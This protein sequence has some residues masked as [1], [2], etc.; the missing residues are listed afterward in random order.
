MQHGSVVQVVDAIRNTRDVDTN[1]HGLNQLR[2]ALESGANLAFL[3]QYT[4]HAGGFDDL[5]AVWDAQLTVQNYNVTVTLLLALA[6]VLRVVASARNQQ[7]PQQ[8][9]DGSIGLTHELRNATAALVQAILSRRLKAIYFNLSS[10]MRGKANAALTLLAAV[11]TQ[12]PETT[13]ELAR[14]FD[15]SLAALP[16]LARLP[17]QRKGDTHAEGADH[18]AGSQTRLWQQWK[19]GDMLKR[20]TRVGFVAFALGMLRHADPLTL[21]TLLATRPLTGGLLNHMAGDPPEVQLQVLGMLRSRVLSHK[22]GVPAATQAEVLSD[23]VLSQLSQLAVT[24]HTDDTAQGHEEVAQQAAN[25]AYKLLAEVVMD[26]RHGLCS[27]AAA[28]EGGTDVTLAS[29]V[30][31]QLSAGQR[32]LL[33]WLQRLRPAESTAH[34][35]LIAACTAADPALA[36]ALLLSLPFT[37]EPALSGRWLAHAAVAGGLMQRVA[38]VRVGLSQL[39]Q[40]GAPAPA[41]ES[42]LMLGLLRCALPPCL[43]K[44]A[45]SRG[46]QRSSTLVRHTTLCLLARVLDTAAALLRDVAA[47][48]RQLAVDSRLLQS[49]SAA[50]LPCRGGGGSVRPLAGSRAQLRWAELGLAIQTAVRTGLPDPQPLLA[51]F[52][53]LQRTGAGLG[54]AAKAGSGKDKRTALAAAAEG[55]D[56]LLAGQAMQHWVVE[57]EEEEDVVVI[58]SGEVPDKPQ[59]G[60]ASADDHGKGTDDTNLAAVEGPPHEG[61]NGV[62]EQQAGCKSGLAAANSELLS[63]LLR[64]LVGWQRSLPGALAESHVD[65]ERLVPQDLLALRPHH[66]LLFLELLLA[67]LP[68]PASASNEPRLLSGYPGNSGSGALVPL[69]ATL[70]LPVLRLLCGAQHGEVSQLARRWALARLAATGAFHGQEDEALVWVDLLPRSA[71]CPSAPAVCGFLTDALQQLQRKPHEFYELAQQAAIGPSSGSD[72][73]LTRE[74]DEAAAAAAAA[75]AGLHSEHTNG[76]TEVGGPLGFSLLALCALRQALRVLPSP[77]MAGEDKAAICAYVAAVLGLLCQQQHSTHSSSRSSSPAVDKTKDAAAAPAVDSSGSVGAAHR[78][79]RT[80]L[81]VLRLEAQRTAQQQHQQDGGGAGAASEGDLKRRH[82]EATRHAAASA[83]GTSPGSLAAELGLLFPPEGSCIVSLVELLESQLQPGPAGPAALVNG[84]GPAAEP[85]LGAEPSSAHAHARKKRKKSS[86]GEAA[87]EG[88]AAL[89]AQLDTEQLSQLAEPGQQTQQAAASLRHSLL[90]ALHAE[91]AAALPTVAASALPGD[92]SHQ[93]AAKLVTDICLAHSLPLPLPDALVRAGLEPEHAIAAYRALLEAAPLGLLLHT[94]A[95]CCRLL[96]GA[97]P[98][99][100]DSRSTSSGQSAGGRLRLQAG[101]EVLAALQRR[102]DSEAGSCGHE[103]QGLQRLGLVRHCL[104]WLERATSAAQVQWLF[105]ALQL[106]LS[107]LTVSKLAERPQQGCMHQAQTAALSML[108]AHPNVQASLAPSPQQQETAMHAAVALGTVSLLRQQLSGAAG[109]REAA[110]VAAACKPLLRLIAAAFLTLARAAAGGGGG[111]MAG[112]GCAAGDATSGKESKKEKKEGKDNQAGN[113]A[114]ADAVPPRN[115]ALGL[116]GKGLPPAALYWEQLLPWME[117][118]DVQEAARLLLLGY[119]THSEGLAD[120]LGSQQMA[121]DAGWVAGTAVSTIS[122]LV[123]G[124]HG[125]M[126]ES[127]LLR[128]C[129]WLLTRLAVSRSQCALARKAEDCLL[130]LLS[131]PHSQPAIEM[132]EAP[133]PSVSLETLADNSTGPDAPAAAGEGEPPAVK[134]LLKAGLDRPSATAARLLLLLVTRSPAARSGFGEAAAAVLLQQGFQTEAQ[135]SGKV[136]GKVNGSRKEKDGRKGSKERAASLKEGQEQQQEQ[137]QEG[138]EN[139]LL[140][141]ACMLPAATALL[142]A[143]VQVP[144]VRQHQQQQQAVGTGNRMDSAGSAGWQVKAAELAACL[145]GPLQTFL[146]GRQASPA[147]HAQRKGASAAPTPA[148]HDSLAGMLHAYAVPALQLCLQVQPPSQEDLERLL[149]RLL[150]AKGFGLGAATAPS[151]KEQQ[152]LK[153]SHLALRHSLTA[154]AVEV[155][156]AAMVVL[157]AVQARPGQQPSAALLLRYLQPY[158]ATLAALFKVP[159]LPPGQRQLEALLLSHLDGALGDAVAALPAAERATPTFARL[160][161][162]ACGLGTAVLRHR[163]ADAVAMR[164]LRRFMAAL[165]PDDSAELAAG[166]ESDGLQGPASREEAKEPAKLQGGRVG[167][168]KGV[169]TVDGGKTSTD[170]GQDDEATPSSSDDSEDE[171]TSDSEGG[172]LGG[173]AQPAAKLPGSSSGSLHN[174]LVAASALELLQRVMTHSRFV[175]AMRAGGGC[176]PALPAGAEDLPRPLQ[177]LLPLAELPE[178]CLA[179]AQEPAAGLKKELCELLE[180][181][182]DLQEVYGGDEAGQGAP[183]VQQ[184]EAALLPLLMAGYGASLSPTDRAVWSLAQAIN[185]RLWRRAR[186]A[187]RHSMDVD[188]GS[189]QSDSDRDSEG[190]GAQESDDSGREAVAALLEGSLADTGLAWGPAATALQASGLR[191]AESEEGRKLLQGKLLLDPLRCALA[192]VHFPEWRGVGSGGAEPPAAASPPAVPVGSTDSHSNWKAPAQTGLSTGLAALGTPLAGPCTP[193]SPAVGPA[194]WQAPAAKAAA[195]SLPALPYAEAG[196]DPAFLLPFCVVALRRQLLPARTLLQAG[197]LALCL[198]SFAAADDAVCGLAYEAVALLEEQLGQEEFREKR[199]L[200][201]LLGAVRNAVTMPFHR[202]PA[203]VALFCAEAS[204]AVMHPGAPMYPPINRYLVRKAVLDLQEVPLFGQLMLGGAPQHASERRWLLQ[205]LLAGLRGPEDARLYR[206]RYVL[207]LA[208]S[209]HDSPVAEPHVSLLALRTICRATFVPRAARHLVEHSGLIRWLAAAACRAA[210]ASG[211]SGMAVLA[212]PQQ[213][214]QGQLEMSGVP[215]GAA[216]GYGSSEAGAAWRACCEALAALLRLTQLR[217]L[218]ARV[219]AR[220]VHADL[221]DAVR[222]VAAAVGLPA[223]ELAQRRG[224]LEAEHVGALELEQPG[225]AQA[226]GVVQGLQALAAAVRALEGK[227]AP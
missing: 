67:E 224:R 183:G 116:A 22:A 57:E 216:A 31:E 206:R 204:L 34:M 3:H 42:K 186:S 129:C 159:E 139:P 110:A 113:D 123:R 182:L 62:L 108:A 167:S 135:A 101:A 21:S 201:V 175:A 85:G 136:N 198:R 156:Q 225:R 142:Q 140:P 227:V 72:N 194:A 119:Q 29:A 217:A 59:G 38:A 58:L 76:Q 9:T 44:A 69:P 219:G 171:G 130:T 199:Q 89:A 197:A 18:G 118:G 161:E 180:T 53:S 138:G 114:A 125:A 12:G 193:A 70:L 208:M 33:R 117:P 45:L 187:Q 105:Q 127:G 50:G 17:R 218:A 192:A 86:G 47:A 121:S 84:W 19:G 74:R 151:E 196:Y 207:E 226:A 178:S 64:V 91:A 154:T 93:L 90:C 25:L 94:L 169:P 157:G 126:V 23:A 160:A 16:N 111:C 97:T 214:Q 100:Q 87:Q 215:G 2:R 132:L 172:R 213:H 153:D 158:A 37:L 211:S 141:L 96:D 78:F 163:F 120:P 27:A 103:E 82:G 24:A 81:G 28:A 5:Q 200:S 152:E 20:P 8:E 162:A 107:S 115:G 179:A 88:H 30:S 146:A 71:D 60:P 191:S 164:T 149:A 137:Q 220:E 148:G 92:A 174:P 181:L 222:Q 6:D 4:S 10:E 134:A 170:S 188:S 11:A 209:L 102:L 122:Q 165:L 203:V 144:A 150:P 104:Y 65:V 77:K 41:P 66:Q 55:A 168:S 195:S 52:S 131:S 13:R 143:A 176:P 185:L 43:P 56:T 155:A 212:S 49:R 109:A 124:G 79:A 145:R 80:L 54:Q 173:A 75:A 51:L 112:R 14:A 184:A 133:L 189:S 63:A 190:D 39:A 61:D 166:G 147:K 1:L 98:N 40:R 106:A 205:L 46:V 68:A 95:A 210:A 128:P 83:I 15:F 32:R 177:S 221:A 26:P 99:K 7:Q 202:L 73:G 48:E 36:V 223:W 35:E